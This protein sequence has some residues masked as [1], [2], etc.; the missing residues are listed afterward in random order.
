MK[1]KILGIFA[2]VV[3]F[4]CTTKAIDAF[5]SINGLKQQGVGCVVVKRNN[6]YNVY[7]SNNNANQ[8]DWRINNNK[9]NNASGAYFNVYY[10]ID[11]DPIAYPDVD[12]RYFVSG[13]A[14]IDVSNCTVV[15]VYRSI[16]DN[17]GN[18]ILYE[19]EEEYLEDVY[20]PPPEPSWWD[21]ISEILY[22]WLPWAS[23]ADRLLDDLFL[24]WFGVQ[25]DGDDVQYGNPVDITYYPSPT[26]YPTQIPY[27]TLL[28][29]DGNGNTT[30]IYKY[31]D[32]S[33]VPITA[34]APPPEPTYSI[35]IT[36]SPVVNV[37]GVPV[38]PD[39]GLQD[40]IDAID[41][42]LEEYEPGFTAIG[43]SMSVLPIKWFFFFG[44]PAAIIIIAGVIKSLLG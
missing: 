26:P 36:D 20:P 9:L 12:F 37:S 11:F 3:L 38:P 1:Y 15:L 17:G 19:T 35:Q 14:N 8:L 2:F 41:D 10:D 21:R 5:A 24:E 42:N 16:T 23:D 7:F 18:Y 33:G 13:Q 39:E 34:T 40:V 29:P 32:P 25:T 22:D 43:N 31:N 27:Q 4:M 28:V 30:I 44:I 6:L